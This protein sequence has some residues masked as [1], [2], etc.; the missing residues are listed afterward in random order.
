[1]DSDQHTAL[2]VQLLAGLAASG[3]YDLYDE[4]SLKDIKLH[5]NELLDIA[6]VCGIKSAAPPPYR[7]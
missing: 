6:I 3:D 2:L 7:S 4:D 1:M 5:A